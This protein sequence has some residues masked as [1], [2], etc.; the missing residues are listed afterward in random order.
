MPDTCAFKAV[1]VEGCLHT[2]TLG[3]MLSEVPGKHMSD[4]LGGSLQGAMHTLGD[5]RD[6]KPELHV[7][8]RETQSASS[9][10]SPPF[11]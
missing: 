8:S 6:A 3:F 11:N 5:R 9:A 1:T 4:G 7:S 10:R 2:E